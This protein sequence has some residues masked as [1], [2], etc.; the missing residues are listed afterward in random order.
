MLS[1]FY[2]IVRVTAVAM[3]SVPGGGGLPK[4][5]GGGVPHDSQNPDP[6][7]DQNV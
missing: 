3:V 2:V 1:F 6:I 4:V 7:S 5:L